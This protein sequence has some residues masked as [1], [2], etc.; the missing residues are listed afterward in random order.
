[1]YIS[2]KVLIDRFLLQFYIGYLIKFYIWAYFYNPTAQNTWVFP[3]IT[4]IWSKYFVVDMDYVD[5]SD[6][7]VHCEACTWE[8]IDLTI[9]SSK[10]F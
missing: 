8:K 6:V 9:W 3:K 5:E 2:K 10:V 7:V 1:M 4:P